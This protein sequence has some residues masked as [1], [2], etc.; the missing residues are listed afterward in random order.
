MYKAALLYYPNLSS[1]VGSRSWHIRLPC[2]TKFPGAPNA[3]PG[4]RRDSFNFQLSE[5]IFRDKKV[6]CVRELHSDMGR[7]RPSVLF[8]TTTISL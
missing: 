6:S 5:V 1:S 2:D 3:Y 8:I 7:V 4:R